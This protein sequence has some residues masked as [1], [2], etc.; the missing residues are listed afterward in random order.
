M[1][2]VFRRKFKLLQ[3]FI[4]FAISAFGIFYSYLIFPKG[5]LAEN[6]I[7]TI[8]TSVLIIFCTA[9]LF[10]GIVD[11]NREIYIHNEGLTC[12]SGFKTTSFKWSEISEFKKHEKGIGLWAG[13]RYYLSS[14][15]TGKRNIQIADKN[16]E[17]IEQL[18]EIVF[19]KAINAN[20][21][22]IENQAKLPFFKSMNKSV[23]VKN[24]NA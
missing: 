2:R 16:I 6:V 11:I 20:F 7:L 5:A 10:T 9:L 8:F 4:Y 14:T 23:W 15:E 13:F 21:V 12:K 24:K 18:I 19:R 1:E 22:K 17:N 3:G